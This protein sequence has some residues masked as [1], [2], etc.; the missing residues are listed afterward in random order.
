MPIDYAMHNNKR[1]VNK[2]Q[3]TKKKKGFEKMM[4][5]RATYKYHITRRYKPQ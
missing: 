5:I 1:F 3:S 4:R 2:N